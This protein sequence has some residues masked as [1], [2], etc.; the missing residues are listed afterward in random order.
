MIDRAWT[1]ACAAGA[2][3]PAF[4]PV[5]RCG[6]RIARCWPDGREVRWE[7]LGPPGSGMC[8]RSMQPEPSHGCSGRAHPFRYR[9]QRSASKTRTRGDRADHG[10]EYRHQP[11][12]CGEG[13]A[14]SGKPRWVFA[15]YQRCRRW[16][17]SPCQNRLCPGKVHILGRMTRHA[18]RLP[19]APPL[20]ALSAQGESALSFAPTPAGLQRTPAHS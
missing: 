14:Y 4:T 5:G 2:K 12:R 20:L 11:R 13:W 9:R 3:A 16:P 17:S 8:G 7:K 6:L 18:S 15:P 19:I 1:L 10:R